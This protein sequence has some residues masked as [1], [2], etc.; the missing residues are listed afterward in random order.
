MTRGSVSAYIEAIPRMWMLPCAAPGCPL[1][2]RICRPGTEPTSASATLVVIFW[3]SSSAFTTAAE[4]VNDDFFCVPKATTI[5]SSRAFWSLVSTIRILGRALTSRGSIPT[6]EMRRTLFPLGI[7]RLNLPSMSVTVPVCVPTTRIVAPT[8]GSPSSSE[9]TVPLTAIWANASPV[10]RN[11]HAKNIINFLTINSHLLIKHI[12]KCHFTTACLL[13][14]SIQY[15]RH[16]AWF[17]PNRIVEKPPV[18]L[19]KKTLV[20]KNKPQSLIIQSQT[21]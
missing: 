17:I 11:R 19:W 2:P 20:L 13:A 4:P 7:V 15:V 14:G 9:T 5:T 3:L 21:V 6:Y 18:P 10:D 12:I 1:E 16:A 8:T